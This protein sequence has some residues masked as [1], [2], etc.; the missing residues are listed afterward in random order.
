MNVEGIRT[1]HIMKNFFE[2]TDLDI[3]SWLVNWGYMDGYLKDGL[4]QTN[5]Y[6]II[7][8]LIFEINLNFEIFLF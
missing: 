6:F 7:Y 8:Q 2:D 4:I 5:K 1:Y 3:N